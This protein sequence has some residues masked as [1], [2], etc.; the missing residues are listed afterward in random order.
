M[1][2]DDLF[3][4]TL[5]EANL[6]NTKKVCLVCGSGKAETILRTIDREVAPICKN[7]GSDWN[8]YGYEIFKKIKPKTL[9][10]NILKYKVFNIFGSQSL[11][12]TYKDI[13]IFQ[14]WSIG[15]KK[16]LKGRKNAN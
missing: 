3:P 14:K 7:C 11:W 1:S 5:Y 13:Q 4:E 9:I 2:F 16:W 6:H 15:M 10:Q 8:F 12:K